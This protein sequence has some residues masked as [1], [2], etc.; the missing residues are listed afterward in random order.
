[1]NDYFQADRTYVFEIDP[2]RD[3]LINTFEYICGQEVSAQMD[4]LQEVPVSVIK[5]WMQNFRQ[6]R[7][8]YMS[9]LEQERGQPSYEM[10]KAQQVWRLLAV[11]LMK[12][13]A[14]VGFL[15]VDNPRALR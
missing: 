12:G 2:D 8:Y 15:G 9:D 11:P 14:M 10:L 7:S 4:N 5:V 3:V 6:G 1:M 13:G